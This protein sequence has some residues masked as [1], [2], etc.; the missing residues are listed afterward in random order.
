MKKYSLILALFLPFFSQAQISSPQA[1]KTSTMPNLNGIGEDQLFVFCDPTGEIGGSLTAAPSNPSNSVNFLWEVYNRE[2]FMFDSLLFEE[3]ILISSVSNLSSNLYRVSISETNGTPIEQF[4][5]WVYVDQLS[6]AIDSMVGTCD[7]VNLD[8]ILTKN[9]MEY[10]N[11]S[12]DPLIIDSN[13][14]ITICL[15]ASHTYVSDLGFY[16]IGPPSCGSPVI[17]LSPNPGAVNPINNVCNNGDDLV[18]LCFSTSSTDNFYVCVESTPLTGKWAASSSWEAL[19]GCDATNSGW[20]VQIFDC[21]SEDEGALTHAELTFTNLDDNY[22]TTAF[23]DSEEI[24]AFIADNSCSDTLAATHTYEFPELTY[25]TTRL[26]ND[27]R[28]QWSCSDESVMIENETVKATKATFGNSSDCWF[29]LT[30]N[31]SLGNCEAIDSMYYAYQHST[32]PSI[33]SVDPLCVYEKPFTLSANISGFWHGNGM[34]D[35]LNAV[36]DPNLAGIGSHQIMLFDTMYCESDTI[37]IDV[38]P[39]PIAP[40]IQ[41]DDTVLFIENFNDL[42]T[43][44][45]DETEVSSGIGNY[46]YEPTAYGNYTVTAINEFGCTS[47]ASAVFTLIGITNHNSIEAPI[48]EVYPNPASSLLP[49]HVKTDANSVL[50]IKSIDGKVLFEQDIDNID[51]IIPIKLVRGNYLIFLKTSTNTIV[52]TLVVN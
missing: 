19:Y 2:A 45:L 48:F 17:E 22:Y 51:L 39:Q 42:Y 5:A 18:N 29:Y 23:Y 41:Y 10:Y 37:N 26:K 24:N 8:A 1:N 21:I 11:T 6:I 31:D 52:K 27:Y 33:E 38:N 49:I 20:T 4:Q 25:V 40:I 7:E 14:V 12:F 16:L 46:M 43:W 9:S 34:L 50:T 28:Y 32:L 15:S 13:T 35:S 44:Y 30:V 3:N 47:D 36:F